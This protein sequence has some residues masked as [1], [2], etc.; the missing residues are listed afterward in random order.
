MTAKTGTDPHSPVEYLFECLTAGGHSSDW[1]ISTSYTDPNL[2]PA[3]TY[4]YRLQMR[5]ALGNMGNWSTEESTATPLQADIDGDGGVDH[6]DFVILAANWLDSCTEP[7]WCQGADIDKSD[8]VGVSD[9]LIFAD[10]WLEGVS[11]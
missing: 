4:T 8:F 2:L 1:Q 7:Q 5:D 9:L 3:T 11:H 10:S 6:V